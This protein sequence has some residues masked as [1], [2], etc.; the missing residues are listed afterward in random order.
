MLSLGFGIHIGMC[1]FC[2]HE[3]LVEFPWTW[4]NLFLSFLISARV[5]SL[6]VI[7]RTPD[8]PDA[9]ESPYGALL[10]VVDAVGPV[11][12]PY[13]M[14]LFVFDQIVNY[15]LAKVKPFSNVSSLHFYWSLDDLAVPIPPGD[16]KDF[17][18]SSHYDTRE[19]NFKRATEG[20]RLVAKS[21]AP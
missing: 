19:T 20:G 9:M 2:E 15:G 12:G 13:T 6:H 17:S 14:V 11:R 4:W 10:S 16:G 5:V 1:C 3:C 18:S 8:E 21:Y 7:L